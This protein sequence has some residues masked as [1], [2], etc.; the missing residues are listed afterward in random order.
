MF[1]S[2]G[3]VFTIKIMGENNKFYWSLLVKSGRKH[4]VI[5][6]NEQFSKEVV[7]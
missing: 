1:I 4:E 5:G 7:S 6:Q 3:K 2:G